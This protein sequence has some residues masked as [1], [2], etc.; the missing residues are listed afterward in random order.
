MCY[1]EMSPAFQIKFIVWH[2]DCYHDKT[3]GISWLIFNKPVV[4]NQP[5]HLLSALEKYSITTHSNNFYVLSFSLIH[6]RFL[7][8]FARWI[9]SNK[10]YT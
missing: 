2:A 7:C 6:L 4:D 1:K 8:H 5:F 9:A 3:C 10:H